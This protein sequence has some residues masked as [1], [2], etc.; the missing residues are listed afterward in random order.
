MTYE[1]QKDPTVVF[2]GKES[3]MNPYV[4][5]FLEGTAFIFL[6]KKCGVLEREMTYR[7]EDQHRRCC[8]S[9]CFCFKQASD[10]W[11][12]YHAFRYEF[13]RVSASSSMRMKR[14][15]WG[16]TSRAARRYERD[17]TECPEHMSALKRLVKTKAFQRFAIDIGERVDSLF[18][19]V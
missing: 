15:Y 9:G 5:Y 1:H 11:T 13:R 14:V 16:A 18:T 7:H 12:E 2:Y 19:V 6:N 10:H 17:V 4:G 8:K 3:D